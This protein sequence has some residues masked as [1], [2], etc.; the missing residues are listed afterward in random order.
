LKEGIIF[1]F[2]VRAL[3]HEAE[4]EEMLEEFERRGAYYNHL[5]DGRYRLR[6][7][8]YFSWVPFYETLRD[9]NSVELTDIT[10]VSQ[11]R[12]ILVEPEG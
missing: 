6:V 8:E 4:L 7:P 2:Q 10:T 1:H 5:G 11:R 9:C 12:T 3:Y